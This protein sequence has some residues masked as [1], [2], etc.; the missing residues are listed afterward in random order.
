MRA[1]AQQPW[2]TVAIITP[3]LKRANNGN[4]HTAARWARMLAPQFHVR[5]MRQWR[6]MPCDVLIALHAR[7]SAASIAAFAAAHPERPLLVVLTGTDLY[8]D[9]KV[10]PDAQRSLELAS[11]LIVLNELGD[12][13]LPARL[14]DKAAL[15]LQSARPLAPGRRSV[16]TFDVAV[17]GHLRDE[18]D[19]LTAM[20]S[21]ALLPPDSRVRMLH[22]GAPLDPALG[23][24]ARAAAR[25]NPRYRWLGALPRERARQLMR[26]A[27]VLLHP[28]KIEGG[29]HVIVEAIQACTPVIASDCDGNSGMLGRA[30]PGMFP[31]GDAKAAAALLH[32]AETDARF[33]RV[34]VR[35]CRQRAALFDPQREKRTLQLLVHNSLRSTN[36]RTQR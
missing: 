20:R 21:A 6:G 34:L 5:L 19:P 33:Y 32:R 36:R 11:K 24:A 31:V 15:V 16:R 28:S 7:R 2:A 27:H 13:A 9:I 25:A 3:Y 35:A 1:S 18:K 22:V 26:N 4:W 23:K 12:E 17:V 14:R 29:A 8:R 30:Y 10:D